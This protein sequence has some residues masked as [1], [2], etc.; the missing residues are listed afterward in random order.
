MRKQLVIKRILSKVSPQLEIA[1]LYLSGG[2]KDRIDLS[3]WDEILQTS[4]IRITKGNLVKPHKHL[5][6]HRETSG[7]QETWVVQQG[8]G[9]AT[10]FDLDGTQLANI[11][12]SRGSVALL[13]RGGHSLKALST[14]FTIVE[15]KNGPYKGQN[16]DRI[17][18]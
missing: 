4:I 10:F 3:G 18:I 7:T 16:I 17:S 8:K 11:K 12:L 2:V 1:V 14:T 6:I 5:P 15:V 13:L 9:L